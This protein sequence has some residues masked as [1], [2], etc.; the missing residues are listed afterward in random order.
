MAHALPQVEATHMLLWRG[1]QTRKP[2][3]QVAGLRDI[4]LGLRVVGAQ[5]KD[6]RRRRDGGKELGIALGQELKRKHRGI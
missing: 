4:G 3:L 2:S 6:R 5:Q 1:E